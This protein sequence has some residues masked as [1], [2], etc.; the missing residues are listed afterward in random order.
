MPDGLS[1]IV[2]TSNLQER[3]SVLGIV[4]L[5]AQFLGEVM[6]QLLIEEVFPSGLQDILE[7]C[8]R[9]LGEPLRG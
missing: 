5:L 2:F 8:V 7:N 1:A 6:P 4:C 9:E 3:K